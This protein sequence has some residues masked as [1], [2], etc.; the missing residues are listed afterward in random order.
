ML[1]SHRE[2]QTVLGFLLKREESILHEPHSLCIPRRPLFLPTPNSRRYPRSFSEPP[3]WA[4]VWPLPSSASPCPSRAPLPEASLSASLPVIYLQEQHS[5][6]AGLD[7]MA[8]ISQTEAQRWEAWPILWSATRSNSCRS[9]WINGDVELPWVMFWAPDQQQD[10][11]ANR[12][13]PERFLEEHQILFFST[14]TVI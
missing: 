9:G 14:D 11:R 5:S 13:R 7:Q 3:A 12:L 1:V 4:T 2:E 6:G 10:V 8:V